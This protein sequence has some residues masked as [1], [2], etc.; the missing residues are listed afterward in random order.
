MSSVAYSSERNIAVRFFNHACL[1]LQ[2]NIQVHTQNPM[3]RIGNAG[4]WPLENI[5]RIAL[6]GIKDPRVVTVALTSLAM[7]AD[8]YGFYPEETTVWVKAAWALLP[9]VPF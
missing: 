9:S 4:L 8:S 2:K 6:N 5:P 3:E 1:G 7:L